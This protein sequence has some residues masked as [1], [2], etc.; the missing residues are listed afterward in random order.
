MRNRGL[1]LAAHGAVCVELAAQDDAGPLRLMLMRSSD[2]AGAAGAVLCLV[3][4][5]HATAH[6]PGCGLLRDIYGFS[7]AEAELAGL[8]LA[9][10]TL[11]DAARS[12]SV[13]LNTAKS[14]LRNVLRKTGARNQ[15]E[16]MRTLI[17]GPAGL[18]QGL[19]A[20]VPAAGTP[21]VI[22]P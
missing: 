11:G 12:R 17:G 16:L 6:L 2:D 14:Q 9:G 1:A 4:E 7:A 10:Q 20:A 3:F 18:L 13:S 15:A 22:R 5:R 8:L 21:A 19:A